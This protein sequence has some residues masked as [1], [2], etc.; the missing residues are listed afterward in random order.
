MFEDKGQIDNLKENIFWSE[1]DKVASTEKGSSIND[2][3]R[4]LIP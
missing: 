1:T 4:F 2:V 3:R